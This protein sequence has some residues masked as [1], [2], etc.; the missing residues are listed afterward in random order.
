M[1]VIR[2]NRQLNRAIYFAALEKAAATAKETEKDSAL[3][4]IGEDVE[5]AK[6]YEVKNGQATSQTRQDFALNIGATLDAIKSGKLSLDIL[7]QHVK[8][9]ASLK[10]ALGESMTAELLTA[11]EVTFWML[12]PNEATKERA[13]ASFAEFTE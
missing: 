2:F 4:M 11:R 1:G 12:K 9:A 5:P 13:A 6:K 8:P 7:L 3:A 10:V